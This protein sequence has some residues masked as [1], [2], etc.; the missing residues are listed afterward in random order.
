M[1]DSDSSEDE[2]N[3]QLLAAVDTSFLCEKLYN[4]PPVVDAT[5]PVPCADV[6]QPKSNRYLLEEDSVFHSDLNVTTAVQKHVAEKLSKLIGSVIEFKD[7][8]NIQSS[9]QLDCSTDDTGVRLLTGFTEAID[10]NEDPEILPPSVKPKAIKRRMLDC[11]SELPV[12]QRIAS[13][14]CDPGAFPKEVQQWKGPRKRSIQ[15]Q[16]KKKQDG[17]LLEKSNLLA[18]EF[19]KARNANMWHESKIKKFKGKPQNGSKSFNG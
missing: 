2:I 7:S 12:A 5:A 19:T 18:N 1:S 3:K 4:T 16:Y 17:T 8:D 9:T 13:C 15:Y 14:I 6:K 11:E 10:V